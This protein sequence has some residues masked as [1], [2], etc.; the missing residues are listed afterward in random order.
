MAFVIRKAERRK[1]RLRLGIAGASGS[2]KTVSSLLLAYGL[3]GDWEKIGFIDTENG[4]GELYVGVTIGG[5]KIGDYLYGRIEAP[6]TIQKYLDAIR[7]L[8][9]AGVEAIIID[10]LS[11]AWAG[12]GGLL[13]KQGKLADRTGNSYTAW[14]NVTPEHNTLVETLLQ[15][16]CHIIATMRSKTEYVQEKDGNGKTVVRKIGLA[17][18]QR[19]GMEY[20]FTVFLDVAA[21]H[22]AQASKDR[23]SLLDG[24]IFKITPKHGQLLRE[25]LESGVADTKPAPDPESARPTAPAQPSQAAPPLQPTLP[26]NNAE[27]P[28]KPTQPAAGGN[29]NHPNQSPITAALCKSIYAQAS[30]AGVDHDAIHQRAR[31]MFNQPDL[32][33]LYDLGKDRDPYLKLLQT[34]SE[35]AAASA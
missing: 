20:E 32:H 18:V 6:F 7:A 25:W 4:S 21:D 28:P 1:A 14:R 10:S 30:K 26:L 23:T 27:A 22:T 31:E 12:D 15:S 35:G 11:H 34:L 5:V 3:T 9:E 2:G 17:P 19:D 33:S 16:A 24:Q 8:Q 29:G 13:D